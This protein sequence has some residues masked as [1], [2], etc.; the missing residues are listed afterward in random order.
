MVCVAMTAVLAT[1]FWLGMVWLAERTV[2]APPDQGVNG[3]LMV[4]QREGAETLKTIQHS[5]FA[6]AAR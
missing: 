6:P 2:G 5:L 4:A 1:T 3:R